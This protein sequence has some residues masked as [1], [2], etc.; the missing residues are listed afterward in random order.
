VKAR[1][2]ACSFLLSF[3]FLDRVPAQQ[4]QPPQDVHWC[5]A[6]PSFP[7]LQEARFSAVYAF[8]ISMKGRPIRIQRASVPF[9]SK[10]DRPLIDCISGWRLSASKGK[11]T[12]TFRF[13]WGWQGLEV[14][15]GDLVISI[16][17]HTSAP[18][19]R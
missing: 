13:E 16:P 19:T 4:S 9:I 8:D 17:A 18:V 5:D 15:S 10:A 12:A 14:R 2:I 11:A 3:L 1:Q 7:V 6:I